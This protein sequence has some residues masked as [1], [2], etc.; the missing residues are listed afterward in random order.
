MWGSVSEAVGP[1]GERVAIKELHA[2]VVADPEARRRFDAVAPVLRSIDH[3]HVVRMVNAFEADGRCMLVSEFLDG[4]TLR[5]RSAGGVSPEV[6]CALMLAVASGVDR[7]HRAGVLHRDLKPENV[8]FTSTGVAKVSDFGLAEIVSG[9]NTLATRGGGVLGAPAYMAPEL[10]RSEQPSAASDVYALATMLYEL[11][12]GRLPFPEGRDGVTT[13]ARHVQEAPTDLVSVAAGVAPSVAGVTMRGLAPEPGDRHASADHFGAA[14][15]DAAAQAWGPGWLR[16]TGITVTAS[17]AVTDRLHA[18][19]ALEVPLVA[20]TLAPPAPAPAP[21][22]TPTPAPAPEPDPAPAPGETITAPAVAAA[23]A[24]TMAPPSAAAAPPPLPPDA[25]APKRRGG[26]FAAIA[27]VVVIAAGLIFGITRSGGSSGPT[28]IGPKTVNVDARKAFTDTGVALKVGDKV[29]IT[30]TGQI[31]PDSPAHRE[32]IATPDGAPGHPEL[33][34]FNVIPAP[35]H[36]GLIGRV[37]TTGAPFLVGH[38]THFSAASAGNLFLG[39]NDTGLFNNDGAF[40]AKVTV[41]RK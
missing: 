37:G 3:P 40:I 31:F 8:L 33:L 30:A 5:Q 35:K 7:A 22:P 17:E 18:T 32:L 2:S 26:L 12:A 25:S 11:L 39:I 23:Q 16:Q 28:T 6:A 4:G 24:P 27:I 9:P 15:A 29:A 41:T 1:R 38:E 10:V 19:R 14:L 21:T 34:Q 13:M 20:E 36:G